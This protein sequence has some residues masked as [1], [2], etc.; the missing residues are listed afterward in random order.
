MP[1]GFV[2]EYINLDRKS[3]NALKQKLYRK[4]AKCSERS[5]GVVCSGGGGVE[6]GAIM[7]GIRPS[8]GI[9]VNP[10]NRTKFNLSQMCSDYN[11][12]NHGNHVI[13]RSLLDIDISKLEETDIIWAS[14]PCDR[15]TSMNKVH[16]KTES[17]LDI[18]LSNKLILIIARLNPQIVCL[19]NVP[20]WANSEGFQR[21]VN[22]LTYKDYNVDY[23]NYN[24]SHYG[25]P[26]RRVRLIV[27]ACR[28]NI[29][30]LRIPRL[31]STGWYDSIKEL[32]PQFQVGKVNPKVSNYL[33][34]QMVDKTRFILVENIFN[35][36]R[37]LYSDEDSICWTIRAT[38][39]VDH[40]GSSR[41]R[42]IAV[43]NPHISQYQF[44]NS[45]AIAR[46]SGFPDWYYVP[47]K[48]G[49]ANYI[50]GL[51]VPP[52]FVSKVLSSFT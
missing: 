13:R 15:F 47:E 8:W 45:R 48:V 40:K 49:Y 20:G 34:I 5:I 7:A 18:S 1:K 14:L 32:I 36:N 22:Y 30:K 3:Y 37:C 10:T 51:S 33:D 31:V 4:L 43:W 26:Q 2:S 50:F 16:G 11:E 6:A 19:E 52:F 46:L 12:L 9:D 41:N 27:R 42:I 23:R 35:L 21:I 29:Q 24:F 38:S 44:L 17:D 28:E 39:G 25:V